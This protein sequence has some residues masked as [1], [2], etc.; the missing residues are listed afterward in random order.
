ML[1]SAKDFGA[2]P[3]PHKKDSLVDSEGKVGE[4]CVLYLYIEIY[5]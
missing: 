1:S 5:L 4:L 3:P 2:S